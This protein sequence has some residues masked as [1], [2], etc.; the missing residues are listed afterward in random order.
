[1]AKDKFNYRKDVAFINRENELE[2]LEEYINQR[3]ESILFLHGPKSSG[4]TTLLYRFLNEIEKKQKL[5]VKFLNLREKLIANYKDFIR[6]FFGIDYSKTKEDIKEKREY[7]IFKFFKLSVEEFK[8]MEAGQLDPFEIMKMNFVKLRKKGIKPLVIIDELQLMDEIYMNNGKERLLIIELF[9]FFVAMTKESHLAHI[10]I[11][12]SDGYFINR[13]FIDSR[14]K[15]T[16]DFYKVDY[17]EKADV[18]EWLLNLEKYSA[19]KDYTLTKEEVEKIWEVVG[20]SMWEIQNL[21]SRL[22]KQPL[23]EVLAHYKQKILGLITDYIVTKGRK[24]REKILKTFVNND[25]LRK[26]DI[27]EDDEEI[28]QHMVRNNILYFDPTE[29]VYYPQGKSYQH[30]IKLYFAEN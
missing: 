2:F 17:L 18:M 28:L 29:A 30:G 8:G 10:I 12:S 5:D 22:F 11:A 14:L 19:I 7:D 21:L 23:P 4:K 27:D 6:I 1:M 25:C 15:K 16:S 9:N 20:G 13:V 26:K 3:P 24:Q